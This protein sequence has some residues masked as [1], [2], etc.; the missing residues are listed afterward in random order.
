MRTGL[1]FLHATMFACI[2]NMSVMVVWR[3]Y[4]VS[5]AD[6]LYLSLCVV[7]CEEP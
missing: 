3:E 6:A 1:I 5:I 7:S 4:I 2:W